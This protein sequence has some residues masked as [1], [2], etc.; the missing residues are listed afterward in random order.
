MS[1]ALRDHVCSECGQVPTVHVVTEEP[2]FSGYGEAKRTTLYVCCTIKVA[3]I[4]AVT[5][6]TTR[7]PAPS[8]RAP[9]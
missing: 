9:M 7:D 2:L 3:K 4:E 1:L 6:R 8:Q 5:L